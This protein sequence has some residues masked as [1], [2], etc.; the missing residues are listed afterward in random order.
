MEN[1]QI[2]WTTKKIN[3]WCETYSN[4]EIQD[5]S[6]NPWQDGIYGIRK[7]GLVFEY[8]PEEITEIAKCSNDV[9]YFAN[10]YC[11]CLQGSKGYKRMKLRKYQERML[12]D[13]QNNHFNC[14]CSSRQIGKTVTAGIFLLHESLFNVDRNIGIA[15]NKFATAVEIMDKI[16]EMMSYLPFFLLPGMVVNNRASM[17]FDNGCRIIAQATTKRSFIG[18]TIHTL[19][20]DEFAHV[21]PHILNEFYENIMPTVSSMEDSKIIVTSTP[22]GYNKFYELYQGGIEHKNSYNSIRVDWWEVPGRDDDWKEKMIADCGGIDEFMRQYGNSFLTTGNMLLS[23]ETLEFMQKNKQDFVYKS[24]PQIDDNF[25]EDFRNLLWAKDFNIESIFNRD[26]RFLISCDLAE[27]GGK[28]AD[29][30][31]FQ[32]LEIIPRDL[33]WIKKQTNITLANMFKLTQV[34]IFRSNTTPIDI[35]A[36]LLYILGTNVF[37]TDNCKIVLEYNTYGG[38]MMR[39]LKSV[40]DDKN[41]WDQSIVARYFHNSNDTKRKYGIRLN[42][43]NKPLYCVKFRGLCSNGVIEAIE[44]KTVSEA[45]TFCRVGNTYRANGTIESHDDTMMALI[46]A[47][48]FLENPDFQEIAYDIIDKNIELSNYYFNVYLNA[49]DKETVYSISSL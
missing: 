48:T 4:G 46:D 23:P 28:N 21:E 14:V 33:E 39:L 42:G 49:D 44:A 12:H 20:L 34:G 24:I 29:Y 5:K 3:E 47:S 19:Y 27:G 43:H 13:Y 2:V 40:F 35:S 9:I 18:Y 37:N 11:Y 38:E 36:K 22:N 26:K 15:A 45:E 6:K 31:V 7:A 41:I 32:I 17:T 16:K 10:N 25:E 1:K 30:T 8:T